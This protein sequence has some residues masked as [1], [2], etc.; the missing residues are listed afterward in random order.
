MSK[1]KNQKGLRGWLN[2]TKFG[3]GRISFMFMRISGIFLLIF[4]IVHV[5]H[6][7]SILD[8]LSWGK[9]L[10]IAYSPEG[11]IFLTIMIGMA[12]FHTIN[13]IRLM[14]N[15]GG[16]S[17]GVAKRPDYPYEIRS[18]NSKNKMCIYASIGLAA[19]AMWYG[20]GVMFEF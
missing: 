13:G 4:F 2:P 15:Q 10:Q 18:M 1:V 14:F 11:F 7:A 3:P 19:L 6:A 16:I 12:V 17:V 20:L 8:R 9:L 5:I